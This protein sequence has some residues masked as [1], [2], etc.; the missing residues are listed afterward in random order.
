MLE[1][2]PEIEPAPVILIG[3]IPNSEVFPLEQLGA[4]KY[5]FIITDEEMRTRVPGVMAAGDIRS[6]S[7]RQ[8]INGAGEA[9][10]A[11]IEAENYLSGLE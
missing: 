3:T 4:D 8:V 6:K 9:A 5:G 10:V 2:D 11:A 1:R 7:V